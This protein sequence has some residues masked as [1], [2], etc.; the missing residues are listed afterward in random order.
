[1]A[2]NST[3][4]LIAAV[5]FFGLMGAGGVMVFSWYAAESDELRQEDAL[6]EEEA[7]EEQQQ[8]VDE[9]QRAYDG[10]ITLVNY[11]KIEYGMQEADV[12]VLLGEPSMVRAE[13]S[14]EWKVWRYASG[15]FEVSISC[16][17]TPNSRL[18]LKKASDSLR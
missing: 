10:P 16:T 7:R 12:V 9:A 2:R 11:N 13:G 5:V 8:A 3:V 4:S 14:Q 17:F 1:M 15:G 6:R 18:H